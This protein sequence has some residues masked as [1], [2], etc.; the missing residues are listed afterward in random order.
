[1]SWSLEIGGPNLR[2]CRSKGTKTAFKLI[3]YYTEELPKAKEDTI[4]FRGMLFH[5][6]CKCCL[7]FGLERKTKNEPDRLLFLN[8]LIFVD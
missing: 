1:L 3:L 6:Q 4:G 2:F 8:I 7:W 5:R